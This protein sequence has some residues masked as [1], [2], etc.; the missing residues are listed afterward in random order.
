MSDRTTNFL[1]NRA[2]SAPPFKEGRSNAPRMKKVSSIMEREATSNDP[3][4][5]FAQ[6]P[7][8]TAIFPS[9]CWLR[10]LC[11]KRFT[12][13]LGFVGNEH[14]LCSRGS[15]SV[16]QCRLEFK[17]LNRSK[18]IYRRWN[19]LRRTYR[20]SDVMKLASCSPERTVSRMQVRQDAE[21]NLLGTYKGRSRN[22]ELIKL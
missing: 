1:S 12:V 4:V 21:R 9:A 15:V 20:L 5:L 22:R 16:V 3:L 11:R 2:K 18:G 10:W 17:S 7:L 14:V 6:L 19:M 13:S 8:D